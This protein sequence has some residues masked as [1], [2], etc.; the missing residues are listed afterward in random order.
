MKTAKHLNS[1][2]LYLLVGLAL[3]VGLIL[4]IYFLITCFLS[5][6]SALENQVA[7]AVAT[8]SV[9][10]LISV[11]GLILSKHYEHKRDIRKEHTS[12]KAPIYEEL[13]GF[14]FKILF[15]E[16]AGETP[17]NEQDIVRFL[18]AFTQRLIVWGNDEV[19]KSLCTFRDK[20]ANRDAN[21]DDSGMI[22]FLFENICLAMRKDLG[23]KDN[24]I[25]KGDLLGLFITDIKKYLP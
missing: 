9:T 10:A 7:A 19:I 24:K 25:K 16:K 13:I 18:N 23:H 22:M 21:T 11:V 5:W 6:F 20:A 17:P 14:M 4:L 3:I 2:K 15:A 12:K 8:V 1:D